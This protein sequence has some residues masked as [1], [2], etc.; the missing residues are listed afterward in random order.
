MPLYEPGL[1]NLVSRNKEE[2]RLSFATDIKEAVRNSDI[3]FICVGTP[4]K[5][6]GEPD[7]G[8]VE[9]VVKEIAQATEG[10]KLIV[11]KSTVPVQT[12]SWMWEITRR[13]KNGDLDIAVNP[14]FLREG[15]AVHD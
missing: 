1:E 9:N 4:P 3:I 2:G 10:Y 11:E 14:E 15:S 8:A 13:Y 12:A 5:Q 7:L 6:N